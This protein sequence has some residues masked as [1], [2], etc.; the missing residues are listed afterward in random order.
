MTFM[1]Y[2]ADMRARCLAEEAAA[3]ADDRRDEAIFAR[4]RGNVYDA[5]AT[6]HAALEKARGADFP[7]AYDR[8]LRSME[9]AWSQAWDRAAQHSDPDRTFTEDVKLAALRDVLARWEEEQHDG[10]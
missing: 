5:C 7:A 6:I 9:S 3:K 4:I 10:K 2:L 1:T 8:Q